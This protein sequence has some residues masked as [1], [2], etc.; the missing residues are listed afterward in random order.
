MPFRVDAN[1]G[2]LMVAVVG[3]EDR[4]ARDDADLVAEIAA[5]ISA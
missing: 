4:L 2:G 1:G 3:V 5:G